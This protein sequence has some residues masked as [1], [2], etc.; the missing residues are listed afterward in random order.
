MPNDL[1]SLAAD[2]GKAPLKAK[3]TA[4][5]A[6]LAVAGVLG[7]AGVVASKPHFVTLYSGLGDEE[8]VAV[9]K[10]LAGVK[11]AYRASQPPGPYVIYVDESSY[12]Q[13]QIAVAMAEALKRTPSGITT[14]ENGASAIFMSSGERQQSMLKREWQETE[15]LLQQLDFVARAAV[16]T[17]TPDSSPLRSK[18]PVTVSVALTL[19]T[20]GT[21]RP[22]EAAAV[23]KL[24]RY[25]FGVPAENVLISDQNGN[26]LYDPNGE[27]DGPDPRTL[28]EHSSGYD[29][30][31]AA[32]VNE[33]LSLAFGNRKTHVT[34][35]SEW[36][37]DQSTIVAESIDP[38]TVPVTSEKR[39][40]K[41]PI[42]SAPSVGGVPGASANLA[43]PEEFGT[44]HA[45]VAGSTP[46]AEERL[47]ETSDEKTTYDAARTRTQTVRTAP[48]LERLSVSLV[49]DES[50]VE[51]Q[52]EIVDLVKAAVGF[53]AERNDVIGVST[54]AFAVEEMP[55]EGEGVG[56]V[57][58]APAPPNPTME[59]LLTRGVEI[60]AAL[61]FI[62]VLLKSLKP[63]S[64]TDG[65]SGRGA[66]GASSEPDATHE[67]D[68]AMVARAQIEELVRSNPRK[69]GEILSRWASEDTVGAR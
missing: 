43:P 46:R 22:D 67:P 17:S 20:P 14:G 29:R 23:A 24:V 3:L 21:L 33:A 51:K 39:S 55:E 50:L 58:A 41:T 31:L 6:V 59:L 49:I 15:H 66:G 54:T 2:L 37:H 1:Q 18:R 47:S 52:A 9:E 8:R 34:I 5:L 62:L 7:I 65:A 60:V 28:L 36:D 53:D 12:D 16:T 30:E 42:G 64:K 69:V 26:M 63:S 13:A 45:G 4:V 44:N 40:S 57:E 11:V 35:N 32:K 38:E 10:A 19:H 61:A 56:E 68:P 27:S 48:R 25:R